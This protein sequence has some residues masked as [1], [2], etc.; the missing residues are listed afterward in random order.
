MGDRIGDKDKIRLIT[1]S[2]SSEIEVIPFRQEI[3]MR[4][5]HSQKKS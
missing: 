3:F 1:L 4:I 5:I 2:V